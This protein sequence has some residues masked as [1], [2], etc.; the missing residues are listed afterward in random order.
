MNK[1]NCYIGLRPEFDWSQPDH[2]PHDPHVTLV[3]I[4]GVTAAQL[5]EA[6]F[7]G[8]PERYIH[9]DFPLSLG[10]RGAGWWAD[11]RNKGRSHSRCY[12]S[13][14]HVDGVGKGGWVLD[15]LRERIIDQLHTNGGW[16]ISDSFRFTPHI[17]VDRSFDLNELHMPDLSTDFGLRAETGVVWLSGH[18]YDE[19]DTGALARTGEYDNFVIGGVPDA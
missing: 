12:T 15:E 6:H 19:A 1:V 5:Y 11:P 17:S 7:L 3:H 2:M 9:M 14:L 4:P 16:Q 8:Q 13:F 18:R 10:I